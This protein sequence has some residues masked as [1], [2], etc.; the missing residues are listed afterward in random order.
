MHNAK[1]CCIFAALKLKS[2][3]MRKSVLLFLLVC[4]TATV[5]RA[6]ALQVYTIYDGT[7]KT[8]TYYCDDK[9]SSR[10]SNIV[11]E[12]YDP[13]GSNF[14]YTRTLTEYI[15]VDESMKNYNLTTTKKLFSGAGGF[16]V[17]KDITG[18]DN[19][20]T[21]KVTNMDYMFYGCET[22]E[23]LWF[24]LDLSKVQTMD[25]IFENCKALKYMDITHYNYI[26]ASELVSV[27][28][29]FKDCKK[30]KYIMCWNLIAPKLQDVSYMFSGCEALETAEF[31]YSEFPALKDANHMFYNCSKLVSH[32]CIDYL[33]GDKTENISFM[34]AG[35]RALKEMTLDP[36]N[37]LLTA[38]KNA[39]ALFLGCEALE[40]VS[41][42]CIG[43]ATK[44]SNMNSMFMNC[45]ALTTIN[46][47][48]NLSTLSATSNKMFE[49]CRQLIGNNGTK[50]TS[51][52]VD[53]AYARPDRG[54][55]KPG[56]FT[57][58]LGPLCATPTS[59][60]A[61]AVTATTATIKWTKGY[62]SQDKWEIVY[63]K[64]GETQ[65]S[66]VVTTNPYKKLTGL[67][68]NSK[69]TAKVRAICSSTNYSE[70]TASIDFTTASETPTT[71][72]APTNV[73]IENVTETTA[74]ITFTPGS[75]DQTKWSISITGDDG[76]SVKEVLNEPSYQ[77]TNLTPNTGY[78]GTIYAICSST[79]E[80]YNL[81]F[82]FFTQPEVK[83]CEQPTDLKADFITTT[84]AELS[85]TP[86]SADQNKWA[87]ALSDG[88]KGT[89]AEIYSTS[90]KLKNL[91][92]GTKY[93]MVLVAKCSNGGQSPFVFYEFTTKAESKGPS[94]VCDFTK[95]ASGHDTFN[96]VTLW[97]YDS[98]QWGIIGGANNNAKW[99]YMA[100]GGTST[101]LAIVNPVYVI[102]WQQFDK[103]LTAIRVNYLDGSLRNENMSVNSWGVNVLDEMDNLLYTIEGDKDAIVNGEKTSFIL[104]PE[105]SKPWS[106]GYRFVVFWDV[107]NTS[108]QPGVVQVSTIEYFT[109]G[110]PQILQSIEAVEY[111]APVQSTKILRNGQLYI[112]R[113]GKTYT[114]TGQL[115]K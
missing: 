2:T 59:P 34:F 6:A 99:P 12:L 39:E 23:S 44:L 51:A 109:D 32:W 74:D 1:K 22:L 77:L 95:K 89:E 90:I 16:T 100:F 115:V 45:D 54:V 57:T 24:D 69:Y 47:D 5:A 111:N 3:I 94:Y 91:K 27:V 31:Y 97:G 28:S 7:T 60:T 65:K 68:S 67:I 107:A 15:V 42:P 79:S 101:D 56:Y 50:Y 84:T 98:D 18:L 108:N 8:M 13:E 78:T 36:K 75:T 73:Q 21:S 76:L 66:V 35:C 81:P 96:D 85:F 49:Q 48:A 58:D 72:D 87:Y 80:S 17:L 62:E 93:Q 113:N 55:A 104:L 4:L 25:H 29:M 11:K 52:V 9:F 10:P 30:M 40:K 46:C 103:N 19:L 61:Y 43:T 37:H 53:K 70:F 33:L 38:L 88:E 110:I 20:N 105:E 114:V 83:V 26:T 92:P 102:N 112:L 71:C 64:E 86:G 41:L 82:F 106:A 14:A 63:Q